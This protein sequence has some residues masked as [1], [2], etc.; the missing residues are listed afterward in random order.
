MA[1]EIDLSDDNVR[2]EFQDKLA[3]AVQSSHL[4]FLIGAGASYPAIQV[5][6]SVEAEIKELIEQEKLEAA[7]A[8]T[9]GFLRQFH[10]PMKQLVSGAPSADV[11]ATLQGYGAFI[12]AID[13]VLAERKTRL[14]PRQATIFTTNYDLFVERAAEDCPSIILNDGFAR[15]GSVL[16]RYLFRPEN[17]FDAVHRA[18]NRYDYTAEMPSINLV[19]LHGSMSWARSDDRVVHQVTT[20]ENF[21]AVELEDGSAVEVL[22][23]EIAIVLPTQDKF[24]HTI[25]DRTHY[26][27]LRIYANTLERESVLLVAFG[28][29]FRDEHIREITTRALRNPT[30]LLVVWCYDPADLPALRAI[31][32]SYHNVAILTPKKKGELTFETLSNQ[33]LGLAPSLG[34]A[35]GR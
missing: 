8:K 27:L 23:N 30:L 34:S 35:N 3:R 17:L 6:G 29:S 22:L 7:R 19:K 18:G 4:N 9:F 12:G 14:F 11:A 16:G 33:W 10:Q 24:R 5:A 1:R 21:E 13:A 20:F 28:F 26:D 25:L 2:K 32:A 31:F 15:T